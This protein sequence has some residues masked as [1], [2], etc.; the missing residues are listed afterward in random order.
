VKKLFLDTVKK[1]IDKAQ[2]VSFDIF[3]TL[4]LRPYIKPTDVFVHMERALERPGFATERV[5][6]ERRTRIRHRELEDITLDMIYDEIDDEYRDMKQRELD[7]EEMVLRA[8]P[9]MKAVYDYAKAR[10]A[11]VYCYALGFGNGRKKRKYDYR[12]CRSHG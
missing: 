4:L 3:D 11:K 6:A 7:W 2:V 12:F 9:E 5:D 1:S 10:G 8:N